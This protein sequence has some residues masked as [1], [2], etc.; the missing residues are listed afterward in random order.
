MRK[1]LCAVLWALPVF[2][3][4]AQTRGFA[5]IN[6]GIMGNPFEIKA[7][8]TPIIYQGL[9]LEYGRS[10]M[11][12]G[13]VVNEASASAYYQY[14]KV[15]QSFE[16]VLF[17][18]QIKQTAKIE[19]SNNAFGLKLTGYHNF[20]EKVSFMTSIGAGFYSLGM[21]GMGLGV[22]PSQGDTSQGS[23]TEVTQNS[24]SNWDQY[25]G[26]RHAFGTVALGFRYKLAPRFELNIQYQYFLMQ[27][28]KYAMGV[29][30]SAMNSQ[31]GTQFVHTDYVVDAKPSLICLGLNF[32]FK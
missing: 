21:L 14:F 4:T 26:K 27:Y 7:L 20:N 8:K 15:S 3:I 24:T 5:G 17:N 31:T 1:Y 2:G 19:T 32:F 25:F 29:D 9:S 13:K 6:M 18:R 28:P 23:I 22:E 12:K 10:K 30:M 16:N 11:L